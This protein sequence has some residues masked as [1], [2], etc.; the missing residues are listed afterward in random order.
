M[1][2]N[3]SVISIEAKRMIPMEEQVTSFIGTV[4]I[5]CLPSHKMAC[6]YVH[7][8]ARSCAFAWRCR[9][10]G[11]TITIKI[12]NLSRV[13]SSSKL[14]EQAAQKVELKLQ[15]SHL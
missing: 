1:S 5:W 11:S 4:I 6:Q 3:A 7:H 12:V 8:A 15:Y 13:A 14:D 10:T 2:N 9:N